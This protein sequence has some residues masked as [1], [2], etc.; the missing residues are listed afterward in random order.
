MPEASPGDAPSSSAL[1]PLSDP[2]A[3]GPFAIQ[4]QQNL[5]GLATDEQRGGDAF[6]AE[7]GFRG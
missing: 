6:I 5:A 2:G 3:K 7:I 1:P 4:V